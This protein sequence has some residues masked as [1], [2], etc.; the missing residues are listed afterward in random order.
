MISRRGLLLG[1]AGVVGAGAL[2]LQVPQVHRRVFGVPTAPHSVPSGPVG[3][4]VNGSFRSAAMSAT[5][6]FTIV[7]PDA[8]TPLPLLLHLHGRG[9]SHRDVE[10]LAPFLSDGVRRGLRAFAVVG[11]DGGDH[12][13]YHRRASGQDPQRMLLEEL[14]PLLA[15]RGLRTD[16]F[17]V[18]GISMGGYGALLLT[19]TLGPSRVVACVPDSPAIFLRVQ[20][21]AGGAFDGSADFA[22]HDVLAG[23]SRLAGVPLRVTCGTSDPFLPGVR[24]LLRR[25]PT[26][27]RELGPGA[28]NRAWWD[29]A[30]PGQLAFVG[31]HLA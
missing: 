14:L 9:G 10:H 2:G 6:G 19:E 16:R 24:D 27:L 17:A 28:H 30:A 23:S 20:D 29:H 25:V 13:Y 3:A 1:S 31:R 18:G 26:A 4:V 7:Y 22:A 5:T 15:Q 11:V 12:S 8:V 21:S